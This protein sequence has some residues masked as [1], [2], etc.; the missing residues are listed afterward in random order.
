MAIGEGV[1]I[2]VGQRLATIYGPG[3]IEAIRLRQGVVITRMIWGA[4]AYL[5]PTA[6]IGQGRHVTTPYGPGVVAAVTKFVGKYEVILAWGARLYVMPE[7]IRLRT[8]YLCY[9][10]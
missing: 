9:T 6:F 1:P 2:I 5:Q 10:R 4:V 3:I 7:H 8:E